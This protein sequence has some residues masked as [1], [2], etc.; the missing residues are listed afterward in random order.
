MA[1][2]QRAQIRYDSGDDE[3]RSYSHEACGEPGA[4]PAKAPAL[5]S[6]EAK[7]RSHKVVSSTKQESGPDVS[8]AS[9]SGLATARA[10][11]IHPPIDDVTPAPPIL[12]SG[13]LVLE[14]GVWEVRAGP[15]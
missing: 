1:S 5:R 9:A 10:P 12:A 6:L 14:R 8:F 13:A 3:A 2:P 7:A 4:L 11:R 15:R